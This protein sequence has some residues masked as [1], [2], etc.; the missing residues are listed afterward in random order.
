M[1]GK[2][3]TPE[4]GPVTHAVFEAVPTPPVE[5][6]AEGDQIAVPKAQTD[7]LDT[8]KHVYVPEVIREPHMSY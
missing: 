6:I 5:E 1:L 4:K 3:L 8:F 7:I 2:T